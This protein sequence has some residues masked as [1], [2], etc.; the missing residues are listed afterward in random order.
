[1]SE[2]IYAICPLGPDGKPTS[3]AKIGITRSIGGRL[4]TLQTG[5][6]LKLHMICSF[7]IPSRDMARALESDVHESIKEFRISGEWF[8]ITPLDAFETL[9]NWVHSYLYDD[10][11]ALAR[12]GALE[13]DEVL[14]AVYDGRCD[15][16]H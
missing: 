8:N 9:T 15:N 2:Y 11:S 3:P 1:M 10:Q 16:A 14:R 12:S 6:W 7:E 4:G 13:A 5:H